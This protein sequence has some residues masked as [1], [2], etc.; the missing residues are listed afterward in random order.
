MKEQKRIT[1]VSYWILFIAVAL[2]FQS[3]DIFEHDKGTGG[4]ISSS[5]GY[6]YLLE[7]E[8][9]SLIMLDSKLVEL[10]RWDLSVVTNDSS[11][12]G[13]TFDGQNLWFA[14]AGSV[15]KIYQLDASTN[16]IAIL[17]SFDAPPQRRGT[18]RDIAWDGNNLWA[19]NSGSSTYNIPATLYKL[20]PEDGTILAEY[21]ITSP[22]PRALSYFPGYTNVYGSTID[23][24]IYFTDTQEDIVYSFRYD[25]PTF[26]QMFTTPIPPRGEW[27]NFPVGLTIDENNF[28]IIN[29]SDVADHLFKLNFKGVEESR[30]DL[31]YSQPGAIVWTTV[32]V[33][34]AAAPQVLSVSPGEG[35]IGTSFEANVY[36]NNFTP[37]NNLSVDFGTGITVDS[38]QFISSTQIE[39]A[40]TISPSASLGMRNVKVTNPDGQFSIGNN[41]FEVTATPVVAYIWVVEQNDD[42]LYQIRISDKVIVNKWDTRVVAPGGSPQGLAYD[43]TNI[44]LC[45]SG[46]DRKIYKLN[47]SDTQLSSIMAFEGPDGGVLRGIDWND[48]YIWLVKSNPGIVYK[49]LPT[50]GTVLESFPTPAAEPRGITVV[51]GNIYCN[52]KDID[53]VFVYNRTSGTWKSVFATPIPP[54]GTTASRFPTGMTWG[55]NHFWMNNSSNEYDYIF[56]ITLDGTLVESF[57]APRKGPGQPTGIVYTSN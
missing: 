10:K 43:G 41:L 30:F 14:A 12:Q 54:G 53:S 20:N 26:I 23:P 37:G 47:T 44:W 24:G 40:I 46:T 15:D 1:K 56:K 11:A 3:C 38:L 55:G 8:S 27:T 28:W 9:N 16:T 29:S 51:N 57:D 39:V 52:D 34:K 42:S 50:D 22:E 5:G 36:G 35:A 25:R 6:F 45:A 4:L 32:D 31:P 7:R 21:I 18:I 17:K 48:G 2:C 49:L 33:R 19:L 13:L